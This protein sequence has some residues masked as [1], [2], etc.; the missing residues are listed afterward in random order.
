MIDHAERAQVLVEALPYIQHYYNKIIVVKYGG[1]AMI[2]SDLQKAVM[3]DIV[4]LSL[5]GIKVV[6][7]HG[8]G[9]EISETMKRLGKQSQFVGGLRVTDKETVDIVQMVLA[10]K[11]NKKLV[12]LLQNTGGRAIGLSGMDGH[13]IEATMQDERLG[14]VGEITHINTAPITDLPD[15][16][17]IPVISTVGCDRENHVYNINADTAAARIA[18]ALKSENLILMTDI[19][20]VLRD[21]DDPSTLIPR[22]FVSE[23]PQLMSEGII[24]GGMI[25]KMECCVD[26]IR[27]G[28][29]KA[30]IIDGRVPHSILIETLTDAGIG[31]MLTL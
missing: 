31:T 1:N 24:Q 27:R 13:M 4:L 18:G 5:I 22:I 26:A 20:G 12:N 14:Y 23:V 19:T 10:G 2:S 28:V 9:P 15:K 17:Y 11:V 7:V 16:G 29:K 30:C 8:G 25:P 21:K 6:L 3:D